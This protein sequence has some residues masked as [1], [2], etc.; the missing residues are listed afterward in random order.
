M[1]PVLYLVKKSPLFM[2]PKKINP[3]FHKNPALVS[4]L[5]QEKSVHTVSPYIIKVHF[6]IILSFTFQSSK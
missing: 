2:E 3:Y 5:S 1:L 4:S 6:N